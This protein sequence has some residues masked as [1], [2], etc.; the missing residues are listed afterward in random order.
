MKKKALCILLVLLA[1]LFPAGA[2][3]AAGESEPQLD[4]VTDTA[5]LLGGEENQ[6]LEKMAEAVSGQY[7]VGVYIVTLEDY[8]S[9][10]SSGVYET[11]YGIYHQYGL[12]EGEERNGIILLLSM[13]ERDYGLFCYG[14]A[15]EY[16]FNAYGQEQ[17]ENVFLDNFAE[18]DWYGGFKDYIQAC[19]AYLEKA[20]AGAPVRESP[21]GYI[22]LFGGIALVIALIVCIILAVRMKSVRKG[23][24]ANAYAVGTLNLTEK[25]DMFV[26]RT[27][28]RR[29]IESSSSSSS[30]SVSRSGG[31]GSGRSGKF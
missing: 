25:T 21:V 12:G 2:A 31:G 27:E 29:K 20:E 6:R 13:A 22:L 3:L 1:A 24:N 26:S 15:A 11:T 23:T 4:Y 10:D 19:G 18:D 7:G 8:R 28:T 5:A 30:H 14:E 9:F 17:L 16:A